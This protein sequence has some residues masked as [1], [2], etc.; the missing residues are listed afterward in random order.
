VSVWAD[1]EEE[2][3]LTMG[4]GGTGVAIFETTREE[5]DD[6]GEVKKGP[7]RG[8]GRWY[9]DLQAETALEGEL[10]PGT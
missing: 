3:E 4:D 5:I 7:A 2:S 9:L 8:R 10:Q 6:W 1:Q